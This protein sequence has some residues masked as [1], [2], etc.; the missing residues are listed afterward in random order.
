[1]TGHV[2][3]ERAAFAAFKALPRDEPV[4]MLNLVRLRE[5]AAY[6]DGR[7]ASGLEAYREYGRLSAPVFQRAGG[8]IV[9]R[10][11]PRCTLI[12]PADEAWDLAFIAAY[13]TAAAFLEMVTDPHYQSQAVPHRQAAVL[14]SRLIRHAPAGP[15]AAFT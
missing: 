3:P 11:A 12:G 8:T 1:M 6:P 10:G 9:W 2:D 7:K 4:E 14:D 15:G 13:P 5:R